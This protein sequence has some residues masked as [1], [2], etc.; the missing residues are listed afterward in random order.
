M[1]IV[2]E[3]LAAAAVVVVDDD[4]VV[5]IVANPPFITTGNEQKEPKFLGLKIGAVLILFDF[6]LE[7][8]NKKQTKIT[9]DSKLRCWCWC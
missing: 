7:M 3:I 1:P 4:D 8:A 2:L 9:Q 5:V 6:M